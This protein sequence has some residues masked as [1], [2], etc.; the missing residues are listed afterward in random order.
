MPEET[1]LQ[2]LRRLEEDERAGRAPGAA[3]GR[4]GKAVAVGGGAALA[5]AKGPAAWALLAG[6]LK[7]LFLAFKLGPALGTLGTMWI[8]VQVYG[9]LYGPRLAFGLVTLILLHELGHGAAAARLGLKVGAPIFIPFYGAV[10]ALKEQ[11]RSTW[12]ECLVAAAGP[13]AGLAGAALCAAAAL[14][15]PGEE[16][17]G[18]LRALAHLTATINLFNLLP[19]GGLDGDRITQPFEGPHWTAALAALAVVCAAASWNA[20]RLDAVAAMVLGAAAFKA[21][22]RRA[23]KSARLLDRLAEAGRYAAEADE[24]TP[25]RRRAAA[26]VFVGLAAALTALAAWSAR[27]PA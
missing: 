20:G 26:L 6:K 8:S 9:A 5:A 23:P 15:R 21:W 13:A 12:V 11:P 2:R 14:L 22:R 24:T 3:K 17:A 25:E 1:P 18:L 7:L 27:V 19:A 4:A 10:I 16:A